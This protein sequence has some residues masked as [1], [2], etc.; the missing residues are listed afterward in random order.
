MQEPETFEESPKSQNNSQPKI[1][2]AKWTKKETNLFLKQITIHG[3]NWE[4]ISQILKTKTAGQCL[5]KFKNIN[6][7]NRITRW[8]EDEDQKLFEWVR[9]HGPNK[10]RHCSIRVGHRSSKQC[11]ERWINVLNPSLKRTK[12]DEEEQVV[13]FNEMKVNWSSWRI[14]YRKLYGRS[15]NQLKNYFYNSLNSIKKSSLHPFL[16]LDLFGFEIES[17]RSNPDFHKNA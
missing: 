5:N 2:K 17:K 10:W 6:S 9:V 7:R 16:Y 12:L 11:K 3:K 13:L 8:T 4:K 15:Q 14:I 1:S